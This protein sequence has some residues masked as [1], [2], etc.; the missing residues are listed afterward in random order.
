MRGDFPPSS[1]L[2]ASLRRPPSPPRRI[3]SKRRV[4]SVDP[5]SSLSRTNFT[6]GGTGRPNPGAETL[7]LVR[8][9]SSTTPPSHP[10]PVRFASRERF[11]WRKGGR[12]PPRVP[13]VGVRA[14][15]SHIARFATH[16]RASKASSARSTPH[17]ATF[18]G[19]RGSLARSSRT[20][21][22]DPARAKARGTNR[23]GG[24]AK[25]RTWRE[26]RRARPCS[27]GGRRGTE[28]GG[29]RSDE[30][31]ARTRGVGPRTNRERRRRSE[32]RAGANVA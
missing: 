32:A 30:V 15:P 5:P 20:V 8:P 14:I 27:S 31:R 6:R 16:R 9:C 2:L 3:L 21:D 22:R 4:R 25:K 11:R 12:F 17:Q 23:G 28:E 1:V 19:R 13:H 7:L 18:G 26:G 10:H 24:R 29:G